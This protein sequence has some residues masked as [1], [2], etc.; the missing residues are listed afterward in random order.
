MNPT[1]LLDHDEHIQAGSNARCTSQAENPM[2]HC[3]P[4]AALQAGEQLDQGLA[5]NA[6]GFHERRATPPVCLLHQGLASSLHQGFGL[7]DDCILEALLQ[8]KGEGRGGELGSAALLMLVVG[9]EFT[10]LDRPE[11]QATGG[12]CQG[13]AV[14]PDAHSN[15]WHLQHMPQAELWDAPAERSHRGCRSPYVQPV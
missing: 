2:P 11:Q 8:V 1:Q 10:L 13:S 7:H 15:L 12:E 6:L 9:L 3:R 4:Q 14:E 5:L